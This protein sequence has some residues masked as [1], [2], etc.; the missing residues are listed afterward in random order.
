MYKID[1][2][3]NEWLII[4]FDGVEVWKRQYNIQTGGANFCG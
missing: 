1:S 3:D 4:K 2:W